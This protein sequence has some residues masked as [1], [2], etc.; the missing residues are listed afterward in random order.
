MNF[1]WEDFLE[2][3]KQ[4]I[5]LKNEASYRSAISRAY[6]AAFN[7]AKL[8]LL[9]VNPYEDVSQDSEMHSKVSKFF[10]SYPYN[11]LGIGQDLKNLRIERNSADYDLASSEDFTYK[12]AKFAINKASSII[13]QLRHVN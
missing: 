6:Y 13:R 9:D 3:S 11:H 12:R 4:L 8:K 2:L 1:A 10:T 7:C 5:G